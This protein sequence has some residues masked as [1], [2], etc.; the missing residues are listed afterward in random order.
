M[1]GARGLLD[2]ARR[3]DGGPGRQ[4]LPGDHAGRPGG[5]QDDRRSRRR[6]SACGGSCRHDRRRLSPNMGGDGNRGPSTAPRDGYPER[7]P[8][9]AGREQRLDHPQVGDRVRR[10]D[11]QRRPVEDRVG[12]PVGL[13]GIG[14]GRLERQRLG[15]GRDRRVP[16]GGDVD[17]RRAVGRDVER[18]LDRDPSLG[19]VDVDPLVGLGPR[20]AGEGRDPVVE[21]E[22]R[23]W[24]GRRPRWPGRAGSPPGRGRGSAPNSIRDRFTE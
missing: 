16:A 14:V 15:R 3:A 24:S 19:A 17:P 21:L 12:E 11:R 1:P 18:D 22:D 10:L 23:R 2:E 7:R 13:A 8:S 9:G 5:D 4:P 6:S 20:R